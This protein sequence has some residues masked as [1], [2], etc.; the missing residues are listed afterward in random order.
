MNPPKT[1]EC[2]M[3]TSG[4]GRRSFLSFGNGSYLGDIRSFSRVYTFLDVKVNPPIKIVE[5]CRKIPT[6]THNV[7][8]LDGH[9]YWVRENPK[10]SKG[11]VII[12]SSKLWWFTVRFFPVGQEMWLKYGRWFFVADQQGREFIS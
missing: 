3:K 5:I 7:K 1:N 10:D 4:T 9:C 11:I 2:R 12:T 6:Q 8:N